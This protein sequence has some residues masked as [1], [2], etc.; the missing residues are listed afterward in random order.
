[1]TTTRELVAIRE[2]YGIP[3]FMGMR[4]NPQGYG[5]AHLPKGVLG[6]FPSVLLAGFRVP[7]DG[8]E[9][10]ILDQLGLAP[11]QLTPNS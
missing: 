4:A 9:R 6:M 8:Y 10:A 7:L 1:M 3:S 5:G 11:I 2:K